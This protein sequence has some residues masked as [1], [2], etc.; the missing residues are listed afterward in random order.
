MGKASSK[1]IDMDQ[2]SDERNISAH[3]LAAGVIARFQKAW[4]ESPFYQ[5]HLK[6]PAPDRLIYQPRDPYTPDKAIAKSLSAGRLSFGSELVDCEGD[7]ERIWSVVKPGQAAEQFLHEFIWLR[8]LS[9]LGEEGRCVAQSIAV[10]WFDRHEKWSPDAWAP[11]TAS[12]RLIQLCCHGDFVIGNTDALWRS[13]VLSSMAR[14]TRHLARSGHRTG[15]GYARLMTAMGLCVAALCLP[16]CEQSIE[17]GL[18]QLR[19]ELRLQIRADGGHVSRNPSRQIEIIIRLQMVLN[20]L[21]ARGVSA[22][23][24]LR[25][26]LGRAV[27]HAQLF[28]SG[29]GRLAIFNG[30]FE[31]DGKALVSAFEG[32]EADTHPTGFARHSGFQRLEAARTVVIADTGAARGA[33]Q[34]AAGFQGGASFHFSS[35]RSRIVV[36]CGSGAHLTAEWRSALRRPAAHSTLSAEPESA[37]PDFGKASTFTHRRA[38]DARGHLLEIERPFTELPDGPHH[39]R[40]LFLNAHGDNLRGED[41]LCQPDASLLSAWQFRF[42]LHPTVRASLARDG[43]SVILALSNKE[44]WRFR[45]NFKQIALEKSVY[46]GS[47]GQPEATEQIVLKADA[48]KPLEDGS[49]GDMVLKWSF[50]RMDGV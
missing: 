21:D 27:A 28:R 50:Q 43:R 18:E 19:R 10:G 42:H 46:L 15:S 48:T 20:A 22:P 34:S 8:H 1:R 32:F 40:R 4:G 37:L 23:G 24:F 11:F 17:R 44:G 41:T 6:G 9:S 14:Q 26:I 45:C 2:A 35:G 38:E 31:D 29:D 3:D 13:R 12:E 39:S 36:N 47:A 33:S 7:L 5:S 16:G 25:H 49:V 30:S